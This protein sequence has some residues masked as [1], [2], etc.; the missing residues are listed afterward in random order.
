MQNPKHI[1]ITGASSG[2]GAALAT[3]YAASG[4]TLGLIARRASLLTTLRD[5][6]QA[7]GATVWLADCDVTSRE[8]LKTVL[9][10]ADGA[11]PIDLIIANAGISG[12]TFGAGENDVQARAI[13]ATNLDGVLNTI[14]P[15]VPRMTQRRRGQ[16]AIMASMASFRGL[17][18]APAYCGSKAAVR[19]YGEGLR[20]EVARYGVEVNV[21]CPGYIETPMTDANHFPMPFLMKVEPAARIIMKGLAKNTGRIAFPWPMGVAVW[22]L[23][24]LP[25]SWTDGMLARLPKKGALKA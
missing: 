7:K 13:F 8:A 9:C 21:I 23:A 2:I 24:L 20:G 5:A 22:L 18:S 16:I 17:P 4:V 6:C 12:G 14:Q 10:T 15:L 1:V 25:V 19:V 11:T 3:S